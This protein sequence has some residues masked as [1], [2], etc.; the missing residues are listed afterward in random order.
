MELDEEQETY[1]WKVSVGGH[2][3]DTSPFQDQ[4]PHQTINRVK[5][6]SYPV[7]DTLH[8]F[9]KQI[10]VPYLLSDTKDSSKPRISS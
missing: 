4:I 1:A 5:E 9:A 8:H 6:N 2:G 10:S 3:S 7:P